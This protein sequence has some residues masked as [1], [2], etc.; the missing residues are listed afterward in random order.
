MNIVSVEIEL[1]ASCN[2]KCWFCPNGVVGRKFNKISD[3]TFN[4]ILEMAS[5]VK[6]IHICGFSEHTMFGIDYVRKYLVELNKL[7]KNLTLNTNGDFIDNIHEWLKYFN[8]IDISRYDDSFIEY[9]LGII[10]KLPTFEVIKFEQNEIVLYD[11]VKYV[12]LMNILKLKKLC[13]RGGLVDKFDKDTVRTEPCNIFNN[14]R[15]I[16]INSYGNVYPCANVSSD[17]AEEHNEILLFNVND[18]NR[19][20]VSDVSYNLANSIDIYSACRLCNYREGDFI[21]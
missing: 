13:N 15:Y 3:S 12:K 16:F 10:D 21:E 6:N 2:R 5:N 19:S 17:F 11:G 4:K 20:M 9:S 1:F 18:N 8:R 14:K 7:N